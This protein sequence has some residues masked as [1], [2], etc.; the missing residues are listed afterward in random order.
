MEQSVLG[1]ARPDAVIEFS[2]PQG[3]PEL[4]LV[5]TPTFN[6]DH[7]GARIGLPQGRHTGSGG[8]KGIVPDV[9]GDP[10]VIAE[11]Q[12]VWDQWAPL[13]RHPTNFM[14][15]GMEAGSSGSPSN[16]SRTWRWNSWMTL[17]K[18]PPTPI[19]T[20]GWAKR[21]R[22]PERSSA[23]AAVPHV[24]KAII[25]GAAAGETYK[26]EFIFRQVGQVQTDE[27]TGLTVSARGPG[28]V[29]I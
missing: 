20:Y 8:G 2:R 17:L 19:D 25:M 21:V 24:R 14:E 6:H 18:R 15:A 22:I 13:D 5:V 3:Y 7:P 10:A 29:P 23:E 4:Q 11:A 27:R 26:N 12:A 1:R 9:G 28:Q 16:S